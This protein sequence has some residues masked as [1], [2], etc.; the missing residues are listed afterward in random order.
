MQRRI[1]LAIVVVVVAGAYVGVRGQ[2]ANNWEWPTYGA[3]LGNTRYAPLD[4]INAGNISKL[5][6]AWRMK[7][8]NLGPRPEYLLEA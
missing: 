4:Q 1:V 2:A 8:D 6:V 7:T 3:D 5:E